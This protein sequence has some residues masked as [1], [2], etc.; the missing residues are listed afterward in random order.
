MFLA[1]V[2]GKIVATVKDETLYGRSLLIV[3]PLDEHLQ[4]TGAPFVA[5]DGVGNV[6]QGDVV[7]WE[8]GREAPMAVPFRDAPVDAA[9]VGIVDE[10]QSVR[11]VRQ[12]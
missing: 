2:V 4:V 5:V 3:E 6:G 11:S 1:R 8:G 12:G 9:I 10:L 7:Y